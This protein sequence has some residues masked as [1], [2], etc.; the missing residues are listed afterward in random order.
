M[1]LIPAEPLMMTAPFSAGT[2]QSSSGI[3]VLVPDVADDFLEDVLDRHEAFHVAEFIDD[4]GHLNGLVLHLEKDFFDGRG[5]RDEEGL[6]ENGGQLERPVG[7]QIAESG[8]WCRS[9]P[10][11]GPSG[12]GRPGKRL[13]PSARMVS[14]ICSRVDDASMAL[15]RGPGGHDFLDRPG[16]QVDDFGDHVLAVRGQALDSGMEKGLGFLLGHRPGKTR[17]GFAAL[18]RKI[19]RDRNVKTLTRG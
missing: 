16:G 1:S 19:S 5:F 4:E 2:Y 3:V 14:R 8:P 6:A 13:N 17:G 9:G 10:R 11:C 15:I 12:P 18:D 7:R